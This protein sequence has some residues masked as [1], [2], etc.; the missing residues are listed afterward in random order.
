MRTVTEARVLVEL[1]K[2][3]RGDGRVGRDRDVE[4]FE[5]FELEERGLP[6]R[7]L[8]GD[9]QAETPHGP[10]VILDE[11]GESRGTLRSRD[12]AFVSEPAAIPENSWAV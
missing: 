2:T 1:T 9:R 5:E 4:E 8:G 3:C 10:G 7:R 11:D 6:V 12:L